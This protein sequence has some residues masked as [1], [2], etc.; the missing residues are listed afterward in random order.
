MLDNRA[1]DPVAEILLEENFYRKDHRLI[2]RAMEH[3]SSENNPFDVVTVSEW[4]EKRN[5]LEEGGGQSYLGSLVRNVPSAANI[6][7]YASIVRERAIL[8]DLIHVSSEIG[9]SAFNPEGRSSAEILDQAE[10]MV[11]KIAEQQAR[12]SKGF[13]SVKTLLPLVVD[14]IDMLSAREG[15]ITGVATGYKEFD[16]KTSGTAAR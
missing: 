15:S 5:L 9:D 1:W 16:E 13:Q 10:Q 2:F 14:K 6:R 7:T 11:F 4:L 3:L 8:R 12:G